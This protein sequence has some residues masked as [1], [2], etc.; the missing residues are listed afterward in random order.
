MDHDAAHVTFE[1]EH[2]KTNKMTRARRED[3]G[4][5]GHPHSLIRVI[6]RC[7][8]S[9]NDLNSVGQRRLWPDWA[10]AQA[11]LSLRFADMSFADMS[12]CCLLGGCAGRRC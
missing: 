4:Q 1:P 12:F 6:V 9:Y 5:S 2:D 7:M 10:D 3:S 8:G 11:D